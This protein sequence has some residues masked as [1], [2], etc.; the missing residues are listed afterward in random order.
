MEQTKKMYKKKRLKK[1]LQTN[2]TMSFESAQMENISTWL[3]TLLPERTNDK[4][5]TVDPNL[6][7]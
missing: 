6:R 5:N 4:G 7:Y 1:A 3:A 2:T